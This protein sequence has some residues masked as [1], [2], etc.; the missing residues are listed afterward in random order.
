MKYLLAAIIVLLSTQAEAQFYYFD[1]IGTRQTNQLYNQLRTFQ[2]KK[3]TG[4]SFD[5]SEPSKDFILEQTISPDGSAIV[6]R[7]ASIG[8]GESYFTGYYQNNKVVRTAD[9]GNNAINTAAYEYDNAGN[10][11]S[12]NSSGKDLD[13]TFINVE[14]HI[15]SYNEKGL[16]VKMLKIKNNIDTTAVSFVYDENDNVAEETWKKNNKKIETWYY[17]YNA[18]K[19]LTDIVRFSRKAK[20][21]LP[22][23]IF[24]YDAKGL[25]SQMTQAQGG[26]ANYLIWRYAYNLNGLKEREV[27]FNKQK[28]LVGRIEYSYQ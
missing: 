15:W 2:Y 3:I 21:M 13:G 16:P 4:T 18:Q 28:E 22:D 9:S 23:Y 8:S 27:A 1:V 11:V 17:Y 10:L 6:T 26:S 20:A 19:Q 5:G 25:L 12:I 14:Q 24:E 7:S